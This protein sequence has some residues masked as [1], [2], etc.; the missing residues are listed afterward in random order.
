[1]HENAPSR[2]AI[3]VAIRRAAHQVLDDPPLLKDLFAVAI[4]GADPD[5][6]R[7]DPRQ[8]TPFGRALR[9]LIAVRSRWAEDRLAQAVDNGVLQHVILGAGL[10]TFALRN[11]FHQ[12][13]VFEVDHPATQALKRERIMAAGL[14][15]GDTAI[16]VPV[17][18]E[19]QELAAA[20]REAGF[21]PQEPAFFSWLG[22]VPYLDRPAIVH[23]LRFVASV[24]S[25]SEVV[26]DYAVDP[27]LL[28]AAERAGI[29]ALARQVAAAG[30]PFRTY[31]VPDQLHALMRELGFDILEDL[32]ADEINARYFCDR[33]DALGLRGKGARLLR[34][35]SI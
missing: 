20:L 1:M 10:D 15:A 28:S 27:L 23:T 31:Y 30:E 16:Y 5:Q 14:E 9:A 33:R 3:R 13:K 24:A 7:Q 8:H 22:V 11:P 25:P 29:E 21:L 34:L 32:G 4:A 17:D 19:R 18:F 35:T 6:I 12:V 2:T 26:L